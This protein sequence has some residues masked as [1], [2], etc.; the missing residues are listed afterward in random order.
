MTSRATFGL[1]QASRR[2]WVVLLLLLAASVLTYRR[3]GRT[4]AAA[5]RFGGPAQGTTYAVV[6]GGPRPAAVPPGEEGFTSLRGDAIRGHL[7]TIVGFSKWS[8]ETKEVGT[9]QLWGRITGLPSGQRTMDWVEQRFRAAKVPR[10]E[11]QWFEQPANAA[12]WLPLSWEVRLHADPAFGAGTQDVILE[13]A[14]PAGAMELPADG[15]T[16]PLV[17]VGT[18]RAAELVSAAISADVRSSSHGWSW[19]SRRWR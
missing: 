6:L 2:W 10:V 19:S 3:A 13:S 1:S 4:P 16:T 18:A 11:R 7:Q 15:L 9:G 8:R 17:F 12:L 14:M 5:A